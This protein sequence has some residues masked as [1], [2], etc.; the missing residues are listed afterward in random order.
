VT[1]PEEVTLAMLGEP[2]SHANPAPLIS[3]PNASDATAPNWRLSPTVRVTSI[4]DTMTEVGGPGTALA[5]N[6]TEGKFAIVATA[7]CVPEDS[8][9]VH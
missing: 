7:V 8:P 5:V 9:S 3:F 1:I 4:G 2:L 6:E